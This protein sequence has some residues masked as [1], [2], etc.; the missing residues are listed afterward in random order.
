MNQDIYSEGE[1][2]E[3]H[4]TWHRE[5]SL[6]KANHISKILSDNQVKV[7]SLLE[8]GCGAGKILQELKHALPDSTKITGIEI[9]PQAY[10][11]AT[12]ENPGSIKF[13]NGSFESLDSDNRF[14]VVMM[15]DVFEHVEDYYGFLKE[16]RRFGRK[17]VF[18][19]PLD[20]SVQTV[21]RSAPL[22]RKRRNL[23]HIHYFNTVT[24]IQTLEHSGY[25]VLDHFYTSSYTDLKQKSLASKMMK[26]PRKILY[27]LMPELTV[28]VLGGY[29]LMVLAE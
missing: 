29:S 13:I 1:Y 18:H 6:W 2:L 25:K 19:I 20:I 28:K 4:P 15:I 8:I 5:D 10:E 7:G 16:A 12:N 27:S 23:G 9:S 26:Y 21:F 22:G 3:K 11:I 14:D 24:A 17:F